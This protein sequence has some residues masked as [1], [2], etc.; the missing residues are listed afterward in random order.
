MGE[1]AAIDIE[2]F[3]HGKDPDPYR[4]EILLI[5][6]VFSDGLEFIWERHEVPPW[7]PEL[8]QN[9]NI[10]KLAHNAA[11]ECKFLLHNF[12]VR[13]E[14]VWD[15][16]AAERL[17]VAGKE[18][19]NDLASVAMRRLGK[20][21][22]K[23]IRK[24]FAY[25]RVGPQE[26][27][28]C[29]DDA[30]VLLPI[31]D[32][33]LKEI[34]A[35][36][37][38]EAAR[39]ENALAPIVARM[40]LRGIGF[41]R[42]LWDKYLVI[43]EKKK[44]FYE[45]QVWK[46]LGL[47]YS[48]DMLSDDRCGGIPLGC[49]DRILPAL[50][51][52]GIKLEDYRTDT[53]LNYYYRKPNPIIENILEWKKWEMRQRWTYPDKINSI[54]GRIHASFNAQGADTMR[55]TSSEPNLQQVP[56]AVKGEE[57]NFRKLFCAAPGMFLIGGDYSQ[58]ELRI[59]AEL[60]DEPV[61]LEAFT[62][63]IDMHRRVAE[64]A[65]GRALKD[66]SERN[67]GKVINF[68]VAAYGGQEKAMLGAALDYGMLLTKSQATKYIK[69]IRD[70]NV[71]LEAWGKEVQAL[72]IRQHYL[73]TPIGHRRYFPEKE[74]RETVARNTPV[75]SFAA[76]IMKEG[77]VN[78]DQRLRK[79]GDVPIVLTVHDEVAVEGPQEGSEEIQ[80]EVVE[81]MIDAGHKWLKKVPTNI[82]SYCSE[83]WE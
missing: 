44:T 69:A 23:D 3:A 74:E 51:R 75:Q 76:G 45:Q 65:L 62:Q 14:N 78:I 26:K 11:F 25:G 16:L 15:T 33:Q 38:E 5:A 82:D 77:M 28:Y 8:L 40:E 30:R 59:V 12:H 43:I 61:Y 67:L 35:N 7:F 66:D 21:L 9:P 52:V 2:T 46:D 1:F 57:V 34:K 53:L 55:F 18:L 27:E 49:R 22:N 24:G 10:M 73:Q 42:P 32:Q 83:T 13:I 6:V 72:M 68:G 17:L 31:Y 37:Q 80:K 20:K 41:D 70:K 58:I 36:G 63:G 79:Y 60:S 39:I 71:K 4:D 81:G 47:S 29:L 64:T 56:K 19:P 48:N 54:T 50:Q